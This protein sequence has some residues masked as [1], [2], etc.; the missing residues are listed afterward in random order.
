MTV[1]SSESALLT[2]EF[3]A[4]HIQIVTTVTSPASRGI[5]TQDVDLESAECFHRIIATW[6]FK[7]YELAA[8]IMKFQVGAP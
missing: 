6:R 8:R 7:V 1:Y 5:L 4:E 3:E 2:D